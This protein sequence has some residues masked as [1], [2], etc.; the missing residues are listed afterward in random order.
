MGKRL[1]INQHS[2][3]AEA[4]EYFFIKQH[5]TLARLDESRGIMGL[6]IREPEKVGDAV[7]KVLTASTIDRLLKRAVKLAKTASRVDTKRL[8]KLVVPAYTRALEIHTKPS[9]EGEATLSDI[10]RMRLTSKSTPTYVQTYFI[11]R[12]K[13]GL[14]KITKDDLKINPA[15]VARLL[16]QRVKDAELEKLI[17][18]AREATSKLV[19]AQARRRVQLILPILEATLSGSTPT[20]TETPE[21]KK[22]DKVSLSILHKEFF[23]QRGGEVARVSVKQL[24]NEDKVAKTLFENLEQSEI[25]TMLARVNKLLSRKVREK[26]KARLIIYKSIFEKANKLFESGGT[27]TGSP[28][29]RATKIALSTV[30]G[31]TPETDPEDIESLAKSLNDKSPKFEG[32]VAALSKLGD[33]Q[34]VLDGIRSGKVRAELALEYYRDRNDPIEKVLETLL[35]DPDKSAGTLEKLVAQL[36]DAIRRNHPKASIP[37]GCHLSSAG[38]FRYFI[39][40]YGGPLGKYDYRDVG[41][42]GARLMNEVAA[43]LAGEVDA[44]EIQ[45][46]KQE[47]DKLLEEL[48]DFPDGSRTFLSTVNKIVR[49]YTYALRKIDPNR[50][51]PSTS[52]VSSPP[53]TPPGRGEDLVSNKDNQPP[54]ESYYVRLVGEGNPI[55]EDLVARKWSENHYD[56]SDEQTLSKAEIAH[57][58]FV[59]SYV[60]GA[61]ATRYEKGE[62][63]KNMRDAMIGMGHI[64]QKIISKGVPSTREASAMQKL[65]RD[66]LW[67]KSTLARRKDALD[68][69]SLF[70]AKYWDAAKNAPESN[71]PS[72]KPEVRVSKSISV[73]LQERCYETVET[74]RRLIN[75][76]PVPNAKKVLS[77]PIRFLKAKKAGKYGNWG[78]Y[79]SNKN[80]V[81]IQTKP[82]DLTTTLL[83]ELGHRYHY[84][85]IKRPVWLEWLAYNKMV[86]A[87]RKPWVGK[88]IV[89]IASIPHNVTY[90]AVYSKKYGIIEE[91]SGRGWATR[92]KVRAL[93]NQELLD[94][95]WS[96]LE[97]VREKTAYDFP[98]RYGR[99]APHEHF[100]ET[101]ASYHAGLLGGAMKEH[102]E[103]IVVRGLPASSIKLASLQRLAEEQGEEFDFSPETE[104][105][106]ETP[107]G[108][109]DILEIMSNVGVRFT[110]LRVEPGSYVLEGLSELDEG[111]VEQ[112]LEDYLPEMSLSINPDTGEY[113]LPFVTT[114][115]EEE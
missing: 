72:E 54:D 15:K 112:A 89:I 95:R 2:S 33:I 103:H 104:E 9:D 22:K 43:V 80:M 12:W 67:G 100:C 52:S 41:A 17:E 79:Y 94:L 93:R 97:T 75:A 71:M 31:I 62:F 111:K 26:A 109:F 96:D 7:A 108:P 20:P 29:S 38:I 58:R 101:W 51:A 27:D 3:P 61:F 40:C 25:D 105:I 28:E 69:M 36:T 87:P 18:R 65:I 106:E 13:G 60:R 56:Y 42:G 78:T 113:I 85:Y 1:T 114:L 82:I 74:V 57:G 110:A 99:T 73:A 5:K 90:D 23:I 64:V 84:L 39:G 92:V 34:N 19:D 66:D 24:A 10:K 59:S 83:H 86:N 48:K 35:V 21:T 45:R 53:T 91:V 102:F 32:Q 77:G 81:N 44:K 14:E 6:L 30:P 46:K 49:I 98:S 107:V 68:K 63:Q 4:M 55:R 70:I 47:V 76:S 88:K 37:A 50:D 11:N 115:D 16:K 8:L